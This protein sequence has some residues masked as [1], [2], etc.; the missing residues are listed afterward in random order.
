MNYENIFDKPSTGN[1]KKTKPR[2]KKA[3][4]KHDFQEVLL[5]MHHRNWYT[6]TSYMIG[7][8]CSIC[9]KTRIKSGFISEKDENGRHRLLQD[10]EILEKYKDLKKIHTEGWNLDQGTEEEV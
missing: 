1:K 4:H 2:K 8:Q 10:S 5:I 6:G 9:G 3:D 7:E